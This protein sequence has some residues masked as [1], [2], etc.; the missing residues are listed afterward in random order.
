MEFCQFLKFVTL[1]DL[2][3]NDERSC[4]CLLSS[5]RSD[6]EAPRVFQYLHNKGVREIC[7]VVVPD[8]LQHPHANKDIIESF[9][10]AHSRLH[11]RSLDWRKR[12]LDIQTILTAT[13]HVEKLVLYSSGNLDV[14]SHW[15]SLDGLC[16][17]PKVY[18]VAEQ[19]DWMVL[20]QIFQLQDIKILISR[21][22]LSKAPLVSALELLVNS[23]QDEVGSQFE[24]ERTAI[25][26]LLKT[27]NRHDHDLVNIKYDRQTRQYLSDCACSER[28]F[29]K[30]EVTLQDANN[31][32]DSSLII[33]EAAPSAKYVN[34]VLRMPLCTCALSMN[35]ESR[36]RVW[37]DSLIEL[38]GLFLTGKPIRFSKRWNT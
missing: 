8:C 30:V 16:R 23:L 33:S 7:H 22:C 2:A 13:K 5:L 35:T 14:L 10:G 20:I 27:M 19:Q 9:H 29:A 1:P 3:C 17:L 11:I 25:E 37:S 28:R 21:V 24:K 12:D 26:I 36:V 6:P 34:Y 18:F 38:T 15:A 31:D 4:K 32:V